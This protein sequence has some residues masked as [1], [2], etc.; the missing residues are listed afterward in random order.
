MCTQVAAT[1]EVQESQRIPVWLLCLPCAA[2]L[3][4]MAV[5]VTEG[6][7]VVPPVPDQPVPNT[8][9]A[10]GMVISVFFF[11]PFTPHTHGHLR[12]GGVLDPCDGQC[13]LVRGRLRGH[14]PVSSSHASRTTRTRPC[15]RFP[16]FG[17]PISFLYWLGAPLCV[18]ISSV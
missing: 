7:R 1:M 10:D 4:I 16:Y 15:V 6:V 17:C 8:P 5:F 2:Y 14:Y 3:F 13:Q 11:A 18:R 9:L 12:V